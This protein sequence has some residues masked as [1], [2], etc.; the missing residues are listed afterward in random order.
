[1]S[2]LIMLYLLSYL[3]PLFFVTGLLS[4]CFLK[5]EK[6]IGIVPTADLFFSSIT[7]HV[8]SLKFWETSQKCEH[9]N[10]NVEFL[11]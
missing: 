1:M 5:N 2:G 11:S 9:V 6:E 4:V 3:F 10:I 8:H 7:G